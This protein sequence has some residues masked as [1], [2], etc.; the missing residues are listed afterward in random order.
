MELRQ[1]VE[2]HCAQS[3][4]QAALQE[5]FDHMKTSTHAVISTKDMM[6]KITNTRLDL[7][8]W[9]KSTYDFIVLFDQLI[10]M[11]NSQQQI[12]ELYINDHMRQLYLQKA[13][14]HVKPLQD[15]NNPKTDRLVT[16]APGFSYDD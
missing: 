8:K 10:D 16:G 2:R 3:N 12:P 1:Y 4:A 9:P 5:I 15:V 11:Y 13:V 7:R 14:S 6:I